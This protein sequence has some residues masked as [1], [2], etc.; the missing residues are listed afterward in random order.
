MVYGSDESGRFNTFSLAYK[1]N[2]SIENYVHLRRS[3][4]EAE[5]EI[6]TLGGFDAVVAMRSEFEPYGFTV[7]ELMKVLDADQATLSEVSLRLLEELV[8]QKTLIEGGESHLV[9]RGKAIPNK[10]IDWV[11]ALALEALSWN[12]SGQTNRDLI[13]LI[14]E[15]L[16]GTQP[17]FATSFR[18]RRQREGAI[19]IG[20]SMVAQGKKPSIRK[21]AEVLG[22]APSTVSRWFKPGEYQAECNE[23]SAMFQQDGRLKPLVGL[24]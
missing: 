6:S 3:N 10:L 11:I 19:R 2:P 18:T 7:E 8:R 14:N 23:M 1:D 4:P 9:S 24:D 12:D 21:A 13:V 20:A 5:I 22:L 15:R 16:V 17:H